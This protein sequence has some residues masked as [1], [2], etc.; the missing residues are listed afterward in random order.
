METKQII[1]IVGACVLVCI[2]TA[3]VNLVRGNTGNHPE[4]SSEPSAEVQVT[5]VTEEEIDF[6]ESVRRQ[7]TTTVTTT[8]VTD[9]AGNI[10][11]RNPAA[12]DESETVD[13]DGNA[14]TAPVYGTNLTSEEIL[15]DENASTE[16]ES[17]LTM[18]QP[19]EG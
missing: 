3:I 15:F 9:E 4:E 14:I 6:W 19:F 10:V 11:T 13:V 1:A 8:V 7:Q 16:T 18:G 2:L 5:S 17:P 12:V